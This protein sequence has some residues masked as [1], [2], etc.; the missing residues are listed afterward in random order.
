M[1]DVFYAPDIR[2]NL[3]STM[4]IMKAGLRVETQ[5]NIVNIVNSKS[6]E[7]IS[8]EELQDNLIQMKFDLKRSDTKTMTGF[9]FAM[10]KH[11]PDPVMKWHERMGHKILV[12]GLFTR[13]LNRYRKYKI[14]RKGDILSSLH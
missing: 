7:I 1:K 14:Q 6:H 4:K 2:R 5:G 9:A 8:N 12:S 11:N 13:K 10:E 3:M